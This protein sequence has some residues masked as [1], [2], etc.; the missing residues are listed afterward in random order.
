MKPVCDVPVMVIPI[1]NERATIAAIVTA[2]RQYGSVIVV[3]D[4]STDGG[5]QL[6]AAAGATIITLACRAGKGTA[7]RQGFVAAWQH[8]TRWV[9]T[10]DGDG[11]HDPHDIPQLLQAAQHWPHSLICGDRLGHPEAVPRHRLQ[12]NQIASFWLNWLGQCNVRDTQSG[13]RLYPASLLRHLQF[14]HKGFLL[15]S[16]A[17]LKAR[18]AGYSIHTVPIRAIYPPGHTSHY[19]PYKDGILAILYLLHHGLRFWPVQCRQLWQAQRQVQ[20]L[21]QSWHTTWVALLATLGLPV[22]CLAACLQLL[23]RPLDWD[24]LT[25]VIRTLYDHHL[26]H[27]HLTPREAACEPL[28]PSIHQPMTSR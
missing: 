18:Q 25:P 21:A 6:A 12:A 3:D 13:F 19:R 28:L 4:A 17:L 8:G 14:K 11:Q 16:E 23:L 24:L 26:L 10:L 20:A 9:I 15:E 5:G 7:L 27:Q 22:L 1:H 2:A